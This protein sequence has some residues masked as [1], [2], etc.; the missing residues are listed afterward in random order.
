MKM[1]KRP[2]TAQQL[3]SGSD[4]RQI[5]LFLASVEGCISQ[6]RPRLVLDCSALRGLDESTISVLLHC[7]EEALKRNGD[8][9]LAALPAELEP[10]FQAAGLERLFE[11]Y[12]SV[13]EAG[14]SFHAVPGKTGP[15]LLAPAPEPAVQAV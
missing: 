8:V 11:R 6:R 9:K 7:L 13:A 2:V 10:A 14:A 4:P 15:G 12:D 5:R 3:P 1:G